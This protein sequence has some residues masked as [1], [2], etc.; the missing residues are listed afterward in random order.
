MPPFANFALIALAAIAAVLSFNWM[1]TGEW[2]PSTLFASASTA[3]EGEEEEQD[4]TGEDDGAPDAHR[5]IQGPHIHHEMEFHNHDPKPPDVRLGHSTQPAATTVVNKIDGPIEV[6]GGADPLPVSLVG[7]S[8]DTDTHTLEVVPMRVDWHSSQGYDATTGEFTLPVDLRNV[9]GFEFHKGGVDTHAYWVPEG[10][11]TF[12][13]GSTYTVQLLRSDNSAG[14]L[15]ASDLAG[16]LQTKLRVHDAA[17]GVSFN[18]VTEQFEFSSVTA[19]FSLQCDTVLALTLGFAMATAA[20]ATD[21]GGTWELE[22]TNTSSLLPAK[23]AYITCED[24]KESYQNT[25]VVETLHLLDP[26]NM[27]I[28]T[29]KPERRFAKQVERFRNPVLKIQARLGDGTFVPYDNKGR[30]FDLV[31][32]AFVRQMQETQLEPLYG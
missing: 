21:N 8:L 20:S 23:F 5:L 7:S 6:V 14:N 31:F 30:A 25:D 28:G 16:V 15:S 19:A 22:S 2:V 1:T 17:M 11:I 26:T 24:L 27:D 13:Q 12:V 32:Y 29:R 18:A 3:E 10:T 9:V 4:T